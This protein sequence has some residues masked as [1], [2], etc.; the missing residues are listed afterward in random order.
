MSRT[1]IP[2]ILLSALVL[3]SAGCTGDTGPVGPTGPQGPAGEAGPNIVLAY[4]QVMGRVDPPE[5]VRSGPDG[6]TP[7]VAVADNGTYTITLLGSFPATEGIL[8]VTVTSPTEEN[9]Y[10]DNYVVSSITSWSTTQIK[11]VAV[12]RDVPT[13]GQDGVQ[14]ATNFAFVILSL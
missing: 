10:D 14:Q 7:V 11:F 8:F 1:W 13:D 6:V 4:G 2:L 5:V 3:I 9:V 12:C